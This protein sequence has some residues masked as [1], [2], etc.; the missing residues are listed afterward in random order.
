MS[1][2][3]TTTHQITTGP[4]LRVIDNRSPHYGRGYCR[5]CG[6]PEIIPLSVDYWD[7]DLGW[8]YGV[9]CRS[10]AE[11][12]AQRGPRPDDYA[13]A[14][15]ILDPSDLSDEARALYVALSEEAGDPCTPEEGEHNEW[16]ES[17]GRLEAAA[18]GDVGALAWWR[19]RWGLP[20]IR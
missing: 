18:H 6:D 9:L 15:R 3:T 14:E 13:Y 11:I 2:T 12:T 1:E 20:P 17:W 8:R 7:P 4:G 10:C 5:I 16:P 19:E